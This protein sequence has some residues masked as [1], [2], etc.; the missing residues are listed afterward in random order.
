M[1]TIYAP[2]DKHMLDLEGKENKTSSNVNGNIKANNPLV[3]QGSQTS[4]E[5]YRI[6]AENITD[7]VW[8]MDLNFRVIYISPSVVR[9][10]GYTLE[11]LNALRLDQQMTPDSYQRALALF[12]EVLSPENLADKDKKLTAS[13]QLEFYKKDGS[14][15]WSE[16]NFVL[17][18]DEQGR[19]VNI[20]STGRD[21]TERKHTMEA[22]QYSENRYRTLINQAANPLFVH[23]FDGRLLDVNQRACESLGYTS[24]EL[25]QMNILDIEQDID[26]ATAR[27]LWANIQPGI[28]SVLNGHHKRKDGTVFPV[29][30][31]FASLDIHGQ[32]L[33]MGLANDITE[34]KKAEET[35]RYQANLI[36]QISDAIVSTDINDCI[37]SWNRSA[38]QMY[39]WRADEVL[40]K[41][42]DDVLKTSFLATTPSQMKEDTLTYG[43]WVGEILQYDR[44]GKAVTVRAT[45][46][47]IKNDA[48]K[49]SGLVYVLHDITVNKQV[50]EALQV[51]EE[52]Y[53]SLFVN[54][55]EGY[56]YCRMLYEDG[57]PV[58]FIY[59]AVNPAFEKLT[60][61]KNV[62][63]EPVSKIIPG[64][65]ESNPELFEIYGRVTLSGIPEKFETYIAALDLWLSISV[66]RPAPDHFVAIFDSINERKRNEEKIRQSEERL[67]LV[68]RSAQI[69]TWDWNLISGEL[70]WSPQCLALFG[71]SLDESV[72][73]ER[74]L[75]V[76][77]PDDRI[78]VDQAIQAALKDIGDYNEE[79]RTIWPDGSL[80]W[81][82]SRGRV[83]TDAS[84][85]AIR[86]T[87]AVIDITERMQNEEAIRVKDELLNLTGEMA[88]VGGWEFDAKTLKGTW[89]DEV[90]RI[91][92]LDPRQPTDVNLGLSFYTGDSR[93][94]IEEAIRN[95]LESATPYDLE[96]D[97]LTVAGKHRWV[98]TIGIP[99]KDNIEVV[100]V[101]GIFQDITER[102]NAEDEIQRMNV[103]LEET[104]RIRTAELSDLYNNAPCGYHSIDKDGT[105]MF[106]NDT[107]LNWLGYTRDEVVG[108]K[109]I[110]E[111]FTPASIAIFHENFPNF[112]K[113][114]RIDGLEFELIHKDGSILP[115]LLSGTAIYDQDGQYIMSRSTMTDHTAYKNTEAALRASQ[116]RLES[117]NKELESFSFSVSHDL[118]APLRRI[119]GWSMALLED[120]YDQLDETAKKYL[121]RVR[122]ETQHMGL[123]IDDLLQLSRVT[124]AEIKHDPVDLSDLAQTINLRL[125]EAQP[126]RQVQ[127]EIQPGLTAH[128][129]PALVNI[130]L[131]NL[132]D[133][134]WKYTGTRPVAYIEFGLIENDGQPTYYI[135]DNGIGYDMAYADKL[136]NVFQRLHNASEF[137]GIG[138]GLATVQRIV[139]RHGGQI[140][141]EGQ[142][143]Q[144]ATFFFTLGEAA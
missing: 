142:V 23:D 65:I 48:G 123:L 118:R 126:D 84:D 28:P 78:R 92:G 64:L 39:G 33:I 119:D 99:I 26:L 21:I 67:T 34:R 55:M 122:A 45:V 25:L 130:L 72:N 63:S 124:R 82:T 98:R 12:H 13:I 44:N 85:Q 138:I 141:A 59:L 19:P 71:L 74:F 105:I 60:G 121:S 6:L 9:L 133:N 89:T 127:V 139:Q 7:T 42:F 35:I 135:K 111:F 37:M 80:H 54:M 120:Y 110:F 32:G 96:L 70:L 75:T 125:Q 30:V 10:R 36:E 104:I 129:D 113:Q 3:E 143:D 47:T 93:K 77:H 58:D 76:V 100:K 97:L 91:H 52:R 107:E 31:H 4:E 51:S 95:A 94:K 18:R 87:G 144:G 101:R 79:I 16:N 62:I 61:L 90:A 49:V 20:L 137:S 83:Y 73:Y 136:F 106:I 2:G 56:A 132:F 29:E 24:D 109:K 41:S 115:V 11:E 69:G 14:S 81:I 50:M 1:R 43:I 128:G 68:M 103:E 53:R 134:A 66:Y 22:L 5:R 27:T 8:L 86:M 38:E 46:S 108:K 102:K 112:M 117:I 140:W 40:G 57:R 17:L 131:T 116:A 15:F 114:G 88:H